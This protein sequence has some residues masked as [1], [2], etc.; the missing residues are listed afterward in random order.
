MESIPT[1]VYLASALVPIAYNAGCWVWNSCK[2]LKYRKKLVLILPKKSGK[3]TLNKSLTGAS[4]K[5]MICDLDEV[6]RSRGD[7]EKC[8]NLELAEKKHDM[9]TAKILK[10]EML[11]DTVDYVKDVWL[12]KSV[13]NRALFL[14]SDIGVCKSIFKESS[15]CLAL[16]SDR[17]YK[18]MCEKLSKEDAETLRLSRLEYLK[19]YNPDQY[20]VY[21]SFEGLHELVRKT[22]GLS[23]RA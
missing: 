15:I 19:S 16:P 8:L 20:V 23:Y 21:D 2:D 17:L 12:K 10:L 3:S 6:L 5:L 22:Y 9:S 14:S 11:R 1:G 4:D 13:H 7:G 18:E